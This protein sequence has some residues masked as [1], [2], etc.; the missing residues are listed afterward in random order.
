M[1]K[2]HTKIPCKHCGGHGEIKLADTLEI[3]FRDLKRPG[4]APWRS[5][6][7]T[8]ARLAGLGMTISS[9]SLMMK[10]QKLVEHGLVERLDGV[11]CYMWRAK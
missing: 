6:S 9:A 4:P 7:E 11:D 2:K 8:K 3:V 1:A 5:L 10:L